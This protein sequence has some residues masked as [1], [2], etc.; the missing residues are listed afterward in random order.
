[1]N[2]SK[3]C[4][5]ATDGEALSAEEGLYL[6]NEASLGILME[7]AN[8]IRKIKHPDNDVGWIIDRNVNITNVCFS[9]CKFCNFCRTAR[10]DEAYVTT[11]EEY[12]EK[13]N[14]LFEQ[15]GNQILLQGGMH[16]KFGIEDYCKLFSD[17]KKE[18][19]TLKFHALGP[20][21]IVHIANL[22]GLDYE[23]TLVRLRKAGLDSLPGA[24]AEVLVDRVRHE[25]SPSKCTTDEWLDVMRVAHRLNLPTSATMMFGHVETL[26]E[27]IEHLIRI[28]E[29]Q[30]EVPSGHFGFINF[31]PW[32]FM[33]EGTQLKDKLGISNS[34]DARAYIRLMAMAR[35]M[36]NN[37]SHIQASWLT[38]GQSVAELCLHAGA[39]DF[40]SIMI[41]ENVVSSAGAKYTMDADRIQRSIRQAG[42]IPYRRN[43][44]F[45][46]IG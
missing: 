14:E 2:I 21:E 45:E 8:T 32:P 19:P 18:F 7:T 1:M 40:G 28:R 31:V 20:P 16:P 6:Y 29:V 3:L 15:G 13:I 22:A 23:A 11:M 30:D 12:R 25:V 34:V 41:E 26:A 10:S 24:G 4:N 39:N 42:F 27:R 37:I 36:L 35:I 5:K 9:F 44:K 38:V 17:L 33:D 43:Q 46:K